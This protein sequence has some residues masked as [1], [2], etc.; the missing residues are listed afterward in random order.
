MSPPR[1]NLFLIGS[2]KSG[3]SYLSA[4]LA[5]HPAIFMSSP[6]EP[7]HFVEQK[8][9]R[10]VWPGQWEQGYW[11]SVERYLSLFAD[12]GGAAV[13]AEAST[14][15]SQEPLFSGVA[16]RIL[17]FNPSARFVYIMRDPIERT[18]SDY[19][20]R[21]RWWGERREMLAAIRSDP[22]YRHVSHYARQLKAYLRYVERERMYILT[23][24]ALLADPIGQLS[25]LYAWLGVDRSFRPSM[26]G[27]PDNV[28]P[29]VIHQM[30]GF[31]LLH[32]LRCT[33]LYR[34]VAPYLPRSVRDLGNGLI[35]TRRVRPADVDTS[36]VESFLRPPQQL[37]TE[38][39][40]GLLN[41][42]FPEWTTLYGG[43]NL[44]ARSAAPLSPGP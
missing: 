10:R 44:P 17:S 4:L 28:L 16:E 6:K 35:A 26:L 18:I 1:P 34:G 20:H 25:G 12:A 22:H 38:E 8:V 13:I 40:G 39:L 9:L 27:I 14:F 41:R 29:A 5:A 11:R 7:S 15:Y 33:A 43:E 31:G 42:T 2:M 21:V 24:E 32:R 36:A 19:W 23:H 30:R 37:Q 3:T